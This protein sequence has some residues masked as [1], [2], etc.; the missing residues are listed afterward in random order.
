[1][2]SV[3]INENAGTILSVLLVVGFILPLF[4]GLTTGGGS[5]TK[6]LEG[7]SEKLF[8]L[9]ENHPS[10][11]ITIRI[12]AGSS[13]TDASIQVEGIW[14]D[15]LSDKE[16]VSTKQPTSKTSIWSRVKLDNKGT[17]HMVWMESVLISGSIAESEIMYSSK[18]SSGWSTAVSIS[19][20][21]DCDI[22][23]YPA[24]DVD[25]YGDVHV[26]WVDTGDIQGS[27]PDMDIIYRKYSSAS[28]SW[29]GLKVISI[30]TDDNRSTYPDIAVGPEGNI[31][32]AWQENGNYAN[33]GTD[34][35]TFYRK[36][37]AG[38]SEWSLL[39][40]ISQDAVCGE[41]INPDIITDPWGNMHIFWIDNGNIAGS[42]FDYDLIGRSW[43]Q[44]FDSWSS[45][46]VFTEGMSGDSHISS[47]ATDKN[48]DIHI[49]WSDRTDHQGSGTDFDA[50]Y[51]K[52]DPKTDDL[53]GLK[54]LDP[55]EN[56]SDNV[57]NLEIVVSKNGS[58]FTC[59]DTVANT[60]VYADIHLDHRLPDG[61]WR[62]TVKITDSTSK[63]YYP[64]LAV[65]NK[66]IVYIC[67]SD[68]ENFDSNGEDQDIVC[69]K[70]G[71]Y[72]SNVKLEIGSETMSINGELIGIG[73]FEGDWIVNRLNSIGT[74]YGE[75]PYETGLFFYSDSPGALKVSNIDIGYT[76]T[77]FE[78]DNLTIKDE[79][80]TNVVSHTP[81]LCW[82]LNDT[83]SATQGEFQVTVGT[84]TG[85]SDIW[86]S[87]EIS[88]PETSVEYNGI[89]LLD[90]RTYFWRVR[91]KDN[92]GSLWSRWS[93]SNFTMN[94]KP[95]M[96]SLTPEGG[97]FE[98]EMP[99]TPTG[100]DV[101]D[102]HLSYKLEG[103]VG[104][105][106]I[107]ITDMTDGKY[108]WDIRGIS[109]PTVD[110]RAKAFDGY[111]WSDT[112]F[113]PAGLIKI[114]INYPPTLNITTPGP[115]GARATD[116]FVILWV[117]KDDG[118]EPDL[119][120]NISYLLLD[121][122][123]GNF[124]Q[125]VVIDQNRPH[126]GGMPWNTSGIPDGRYAIEISVTDGYHVVT[127][128]SS[129]LVEIIHSSADVLP[130]S[131]YFS[132]PRDGMG[133]V[134]VDTD[135]EVFVSE[136]IDADSL[137]NKN[138]YLE[139][140]TGTRILCDIS[141][142]QVASQQH[143]ILFKILLDP[144][145][146]LEENSTYRVVVSTNVTD[147][148]GNPFD[149]NGNGISEG[150][151]IDRWMFTFTTEEVVGEVDL[152]PPRVLST[153]PK[154]DSVD[155]PVDT[156]IWFRFSEAI[157]TESIDDSTIKFI[158]GDQKNISFTWNYLE[159]QQAILISP[160][161]ELENGRF[162]EIYI[163]SNLTDLEGNSLDGDGDGKAEGNEDEIRLA[164]LTT[165]S[166]DKEEE[167]NVVLIQLVLSTIVAVLV[168]AGI[169]SYYLFRKQKPPTITDVFIVHRDGTLVNHVS[170]GGKLE[171]S[172][173][174]MSGMLTAI[175]DFVSD[176]LD[177]K[178][179]DELNEISH[180]D[181][182]ILLEHGKYVYL[183]LVCTGE[184]PSEIRKK[185]RKVLRQVERDYKNELK[186][187]DGDED[188]VKAIGGLTSELLTI[189]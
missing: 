48:G 98:R 133:G 106:W 77:P 66:G 79:T 101:D 84:Q 92:D 188:K 42:G 25:K 146:I 99:I 110:L 52:W 24:L 168:I 178:D 126:T 50:Y 128:R 63:A 94:S 125:P 23:V 15:H 149:G 20:D 21:P 59:W 175:Q 12:P 5:I 158:D 69:S 124:S 54:V 117:A 37:D 143:G 151:N 189:E 47:A 56:I 164:F 116:E 166:T 177:S 115:E 119:L 123:S 113:N 134:S 150:P 78:P 38:K 111:E 45:L 163:S 121:E 9:T 10:D 31:H 40:I 105:D 49:I 127:K 187:W 61:T 104:D 180:G 43:N 107:T 162:Y 172:K 90:G 46:K 86:D 154:D 186:L 73:T 95:R 167:P 97:E 96:K 67:W 39:Y 138:V 129:G 103:K 62:D 85:Y 30:G 120:V 170:S 185:M 174:S 29:S 28:K 173:Y 179:G 32:I 22:S 35:D 142:V 144:Y 74:P 36:F 8:E 136:P 139:N 60:G 11:F 82:E 2:F 81:T 102:D 58:V 6:T 140:S 57:Y 159:E 34:N 71:S 145:S 132:Y 1:M 65:D 161:E 17:L 176:S 3:P 53:E 108:L 80:R 169:V 131:P 122:A 75:Y 171:R 184:A 70:Y 14:A 55:N 141:Y 76:K 51:Q 83:D 44:T 41:S 157:D 181:N 137:T 88:S 93:K 18:N 153:T 26:V 152:V 27:G 89:E 7:D 100:T 68:N 33:C 156:E 148:A 16:V 72:P 182:R 160:D 112:W 4:G 114:D 147:R 183:A 135:I 165:E 109:E 19:D 13:I 64:D 155:V 130:P 87:G 91:T 118:P